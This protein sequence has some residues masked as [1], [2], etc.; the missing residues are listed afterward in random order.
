MNLP[1]AVL[2]LRWMTW[3]TFRQARASGILWL[4]L[5]VSLLC[6]LF[7]LS[8]GI[9]GNQSLHRPDEPA[10]FLPRNDPI[11]KNPAKL[12]KQGVDVVQGELRLAFGAVRLPQGRDA[13]DSVRFLQ[14]IL[15]GGVADALGLLLC[16]IWTA[17]FLPTFLEPSAAGVLFSKPVPR[18]WLLAGKYLSVLAFVGFQATIFVGGTWAALGIATG[19]WIPEYLVCIPL[20]LL[21][22]AV[23]YSASVL[24][25]VCTR[26][27]VACVFGSIL[28]WFL[29]WG[30]NYGRHMLVALPSLDA[31]TTP[32]PP[33][34]QTLVDVFYWIMPKPADF[35]MLLQSA[36]H[37]GDH[38]A[39]VPAF[40]AVQQLGEF[41]PELSILSSLAFALV[42]L[43]T[44]AWQLVKTDY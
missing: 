16:L 26:S 25:A 7:C 35:G 29:C 10:E 23:M 19:L 3:D 15:A 43:A 24:L 13:E 36:L 44:A 42:M 40:T 21:H 27:T 37:A 14:L 41:Y 1:T 6:T 4:M 2:T 20:L 18:W 30:L 22:F 11:A 39:T 5:G 28:F 32:F 33:A 9:Q 38:F 17:G 8:A 34:F 12:D 31:G